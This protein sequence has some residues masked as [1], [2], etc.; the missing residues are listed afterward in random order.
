MIMTPREIEDNA[1]AWTVDDVIVQLQAL[2]GETRKRPFA[3]WDS[4]YGDSPYYGQLSLQEQ[5]VT[6]T[7]D[8]TPEMLNELK[9]FRDEQDAVRRSRLW[10][11]PEVQDAK[12][13]GLL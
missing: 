10:A 2:P 7:P 3:V 6:V 1:K 11:Q 13:K 8:W 5:F 4:E 12:K 9:K